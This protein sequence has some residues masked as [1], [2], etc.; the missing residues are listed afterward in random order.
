[1]NWDVVEVKV[2][3]PLSLYVRFH[4]GTRG[5]VRFESSFLT[6]VFQALKDQ[7]LFEQVH[8]DAGAVVW[9]GD[10]DLAPDAMYHEIKKQ[11]EWVLR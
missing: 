10:L 11:G 2:E 3:A 4:D 7:S 5:R 6:G 8:V 9:P 1:M